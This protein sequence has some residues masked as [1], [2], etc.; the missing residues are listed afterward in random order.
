MPGFDETTL[1]RRLLS[2]PETPETPETNG[3]VAGR[4]RLLLG[5]SF[6]VFGL[7]NN[8]EKTTSSLRAH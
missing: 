7:M 4:L 8:G 3:K 5:A 6:F 2:T 1:E